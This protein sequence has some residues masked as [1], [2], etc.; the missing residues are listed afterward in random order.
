MT[1]IVNRMGFL[2]VQPESGYPEVLQIVPPKI[3]GISEPIRY[4]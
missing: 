4:N 3:R 2:A 1:T